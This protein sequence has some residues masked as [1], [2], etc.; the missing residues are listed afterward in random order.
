MSS[1][2]KVEERVF[3]FSLCVLVDL[4]SEVVV[5]LKASYLRS[6]NKKTTKLKNIKILREDKT[7]LIRLSLYISSPIG[8]F[9]KRFPSIVNNGYPVGCAMPSLIHTVASSPESMNDTVGASVITYIIKGIMKDRIP[10]NNLDLKNRFCLTNLNYE[11]S[12]M[13]MKLIKIC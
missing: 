5:L 6:L 2:F 8:S 1:I 13:E 9:E 11:V 10:K 12:L 3:V 4:V 7:A